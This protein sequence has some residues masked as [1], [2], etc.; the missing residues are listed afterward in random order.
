MYQQDIKK[1]LDIWGEELQINMCIE[2]MS[3]LTKELCK[4]TRQK[5][6]SKIQQATKDNIC[7]EL[8]DVCNCIEQMTLFFGKDKVEKIRKQKIE[9]TNARINGA[10]IDFENSST[11]VFEFDEIVMRPF[12]FE[13]ATDM[14]ENYCSDNEVTK[15]LTW[16]THKS[17][18]QTQEYLQSFLY[19]YNT[20][21]FF[22]W[23]IV[24]KKTNKVIGAIDLNSK[25]NFG[26]ELGYVLSKKYWGKGIIPMCARKVIDYAFQLGFR[27]IFAKCMVENNNSERVMQKIGMQYE[28]IMRKIFVKGDYMADAKIYSLVC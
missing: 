7:E 14:F 21:N 8:A 16:Q 28:G 2:E 15:Y 27:R 24:D 11:K 9:R 26:G 3:E 18:A 23:A 22:Y 1:Y 20:D 12:H 25:D 17:I 5:K 6:I 10:N 19:K 4:Y 13:D